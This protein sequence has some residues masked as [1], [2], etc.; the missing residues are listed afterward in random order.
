MAQG[1]GHTHAS[2][3]LADLKALGRLVLELTGDAHLSRAV[4]GANTGRQALDL[5]LA[6]QA[7]PVVA[8]V[9]HRMLAALRSYAGPGPTLTAVILGF[10]GE[11]LWQ[12][13]NRGA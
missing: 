9:G 10:A 1:W 3:G 11:P 7:A 2:R 12:E 13:E 6:A 5:L 8:A 4:S